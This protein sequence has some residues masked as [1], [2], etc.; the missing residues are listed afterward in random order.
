MKSEIDFGF[1]NLGARDVYERLAV[2]IAGGKTSLGDAIYDIGLALAEAKTR[3]G[4]GM[5]LEFLRDDRVKYEPRAAQILMKIARADDGRILAGLGVA[6][7]V[8]LLRVSME[9]RNHLLRQHNL[10]DISV[11]RLRELIEE[12]L[13]RKSAFRSTRRT[14]AKEPFPT[15]IAWAAGVLQLPIHSISLA[16]I[17]TAFRELAKV[18]HPDK[19]FAADGKLVRTIYQARDTLLA[20]VGQ[21]KAA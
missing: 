4:H 6:K 20:H 15:Q 16:S 3:L 8:Q 1:E 21:A 9:K 17:Q 11:A 18:F 5:F 19:G 13:G 2:R 12:I 14:S 7:A 10:H